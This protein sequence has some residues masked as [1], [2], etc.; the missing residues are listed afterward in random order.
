MSAITIK[1]YI[2][3]VYHSIKQLKTCSY[4][5]LFS[6]RVTGSYSQ[7]TQTTQALTDLS[8]TPPLGVPELDRP[9][10]NLLPHGTGP[11]P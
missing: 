10:A 6:L 2:T 9:A 8:G 4:M 7:A 3:I 11:T 1:S 5:L